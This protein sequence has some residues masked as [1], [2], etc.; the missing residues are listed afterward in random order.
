MELHA[1]LVLAMA[2]FLTPIAIDAAV[3]ALRRR[4]RY[5][6]NDVLANLTLS[7]LT[8]VG[9]A[10]IAGLT[11]WIYVRVQRVGTLFALP[12]G[13]LT[14]WLLAFIAYDF[15]YYWA[16]RMHHEIALLWGVHAVHHAGEDMN[17]G[18]A[19]RQS[20]LGELTTWAF[21]LPLAILGV[22]PEVY[23]GVA[24]IQLLFQYFIHN[25]YVPALGWVEW[26]LVTPSQHRV[27]HGRN[28]QYCDKNYG[29][30]LVIWDRLFGTYQA[31]LPDQPVVYG[32]RHSVKTWNPLTLHAHTFVEI[33]RKAASC[34]R[35]LDKLRCFYK[36][37]S[38]VPP[39]LI[40]RGYAGPH[41]DGPSRSFVKY[42]PPMS[43][44]RAVYCV[45]Q[46]VALLGI[47]ALTMLTMSAL[48]ALTAGVA[49]GLIVVHAWSLGGL[50]DNQPRFW[51]LEV[52]RLAA[53]AVIV[54]PLALHEGLSPGLALLPSVAFAACCLIYLLRFRAGFAP[55]ALV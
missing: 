16:H 26:V 20:A 25:T 22:P 18:L 49:I 10:L 36:G 48:S 14:T 42:D 11:L 44:S 41:D 54:P 34:R 40:A 51:R 8:V 37:P 3:A 7:L 4:R 2:V 15:F 23:L 24:G 47:V 53:L 5:R 52:V 17:F 39:S 38:W 1:Q 31:E 21:F 32:L 12:A 29:N 43:R 19:V 45:V 35:A 30:I 27:H 55:V 28:T 46:F 9:S 6:L 33:W 13:G 50:L